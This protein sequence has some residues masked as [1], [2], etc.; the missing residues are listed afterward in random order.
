MAK[1]RKVSTQIWN[2]TKFR[3]LTD[4]GKMVFLFILTHP[5]M[6]SLGGM[7]ATTQGLAAELGWSFD[8]FS[9]GFAEPFRKGMV[10]YD[11]T[12]SCIVLPNFLK[13]N[14]PENPNVVKSWSKA[15]D[16]IPECELKYQ[17]ISDAKTLCEGL[18][19]NF[20]K[21]FVNAFETVSKGFA[22]PFRI[23]EQEQEQE[24]EQ[25]LLCFSKEKPGGDPQPE[26][27]CAPSEPPSGGLLSKKSKSKHFS[28][29]ITD[30]LPEIKRA[31]TKLSE[32]S[33][34]NGKKFNP[35]MFVQKQ[36]NVRGHPGA[37][38]ESLDGVIVLWDSIDSPWPYAEKIM[39]TKNGNWNE[40]D[41]QQQAQEFKNLVLDKDVKKLLDGIGT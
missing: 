9:K 26:Q 8:K 22:K 14:P 10:K 11:E 30:L 2:D 19:E 5:H 39:K 12:A 32:L 7:R 3:D 15:A 4:D 37:I 24:Q 27:A 38:L 25:E 20:R 13:H 16:M 40:R 6:T 31:C 28:S 21:A 35:Y 23:P 17:I 1:Y 36:A 18:K 34:L 41:H 29:T 33:A